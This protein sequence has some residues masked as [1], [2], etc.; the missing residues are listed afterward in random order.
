MLV[1]DQVL[2]D[3]W[4]VAARAEDI[5]EEPQQVIVLGERIVLFRTEVGIHA[6]K[7]LCI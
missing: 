7:D 1:E 6:F 2:R 4:I 5:K 3:Q